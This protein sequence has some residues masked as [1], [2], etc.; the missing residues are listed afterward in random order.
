M[1]SSLTALPL[2]VFRVRHGVHHGVRHGD[3]HGVRVHRNHSHHNHN[4]NHYLRKSSRLPKQ[5]SI[6]VNHQFH[7][8]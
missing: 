3:H 2:N 4:P 6:D 1:G 7:Y 5:Y 8:H